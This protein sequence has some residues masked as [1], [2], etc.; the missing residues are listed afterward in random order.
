MKLLIEETDR[1]SLDFL[2]ESDA[3][4]GVKSFRVRGVFAM[5][6]VENKNRRIYPRHILER[7]VMTYQGRIRE[8]RAVG[9]LEHPAS[10]M[11]NLER[12]SHLVEHLEMQGNNVYGVAKV[13][14]TPLGR[15]AKT[16]MSE[17][18]KLGVSTRGLG[19]LNGNKV[20]SSYS[21][22]A[23]DMV[24]EPSAPSAIVDAI[25]E[26][27]EWI[28]NGDSIVEVAV[29]DFAKK[30]DKHGSK[31]AHDALAQFLKDLK[32]RL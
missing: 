28:I 6:E 1:Q 10:P 3:S 15:I 13:L 32:T 2:I 30:L 31:I 5:S 9:E 4:T 12:V 11:I 24:H 7:E 22:R 27:R 23:I 19:T 18:I 20:E 25:M 16:L 26:S 21:M 14:D 8:K 17:G 29:S